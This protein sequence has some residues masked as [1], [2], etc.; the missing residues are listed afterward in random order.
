MSGLGSSSFLSS[1]KRIRAA[2]QCGHNCA[3]NKPSTEWPR[4]QELITGA[5]LLPISRSLK[6]D[7][8][9]NEQNAKQQVPVCLN[10]VPPSSRAM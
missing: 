3:I 4:A 1:Q 7:S 8:Y 9:L 6:F 2:L 5:C 10:K